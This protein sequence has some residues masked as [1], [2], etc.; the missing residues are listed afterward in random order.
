MTYLLNTKESPKNYLMAQGTTYLTY[1]SI[2]RQLETIRYCRALL[3]NEFLKP[4]S[5][6]V[7][8]SLFMLRP[9]AQVNTTQQRLL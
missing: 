3:L 7:M 6:G 8:F 1:E 2:I 5:V 9:N 4:S